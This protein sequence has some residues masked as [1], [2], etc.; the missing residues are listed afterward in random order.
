MT[1]TARPEDWGNNLSEINRAVS[2]VSGLCSAEGLAQSMASQ[3]PPCLACKYWH[4]HY[5]DNVGFCVKN[6]EIHRDFSCFRDKRHEGDL[7]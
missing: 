6:G 3:G 7:A 4:L 5:H 2:K 1:T